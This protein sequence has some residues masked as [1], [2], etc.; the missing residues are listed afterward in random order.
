MALLNMLWRFVKN[1]PVWF[2]GTFIVSWF[3]VPVAVLQADEDG[4]LPR[5]A[6]WLETFD[7]LGWEGLFEEE[8]LTKRYNFWQERLDDWWARRITL[9]TWLWRN[10]A[11]AL[12]SSMG[13][14]LPDLKTFRVVWQLGTFSK[15]RIFNLSIIIVEINDKWYFEAQP[16]LGWGGVY[17]YLRIGWKLTTFRNGKMPNL[18]NNGGM[19]TGITPRYST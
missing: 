6:W 5:W 8:T 4:R 1:I 7:N 12:R 9:M 18:N 19:Y 13:V 11:Y 10:K 17:L 14:H 15:P 2:I 3:A 16:R